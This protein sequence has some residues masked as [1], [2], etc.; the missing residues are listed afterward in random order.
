MAP[1]TTS[2][3]SSP[4][5]Q[6]TAR[7][8]SPAAELWS[9]RS[10]LWLLTVRDI[11]VRYAGSMLGIMWNVIH[12]VVMILIYILILGSILP[13]KMGGGVSRGDYVVHLC[14]GMIPWLVF[15]E[16]LMRS[17]TTLLENAT[18][19]KK[20]AFPEI[21]LH[22]SVVLNAVFIHFISFVAFILILLVMGLWPGAIVLVCFGILAA[23]AIFALGLGL[24]FSVLNI[25]FRDVGQ[26]VTIGLQF[27]FWFTPIVYMPELILRGSGRTTRVIG[28]LLEVNPVMH[29]TRMSQWV[30]GG[31][32]PNAFFSRVDLALVLLAPCLAL[33]LGL[34]M[35]NRF[36]HDML[37]HI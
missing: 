27:L 33:A 2:P 34:T 31:T 13:G 1:H 25:Y 32:E 37:D 21:I 5:Q 24:V 29:F 22:L 6:R 36:K 23:I 30:F 14:A 7:R 9:H 17:S 16:I 10:I 3:P 4:A 8:R 26:V 18:L 11:K 35:F 19:I 20:V 15:Q 28:A 12:P